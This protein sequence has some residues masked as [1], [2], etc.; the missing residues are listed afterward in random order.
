MRN[1]LWVFVIAAMLGDMGLPAAHAQKGVGDDTGVARQA[2]RPE[3]VTL[4]GT[5]TAVETGPCKNT[6]GRALVGTHVLLKASDGKT[7][8]VHLGPAPVVESTAKLLAKDAEVKVT[9]FRTGAM[10]ENH[11]VA[12]SLTVGEETVTLRDETL[13]PD[14]AGPQRANRGRGAMQGGYGRG[15]G[16]GYGQGR[17]QGYGRGGGRGYG[18]GQGCPWAA[19]S[20]DDWRPRQCQWSSGSSGGRGYG[21]GSGAGRGGGKGAGRGNGGGR[22]QGRGAGRNAGW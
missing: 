15:R 8:N 14:W 9:A 11:Y 2:I 18:A 5:V 21:Y 6:T 17:G 19:E 22:G 4:Q 1:Y 12:Q 10:P 3:I 16:Q 13:R 7:L 20:S